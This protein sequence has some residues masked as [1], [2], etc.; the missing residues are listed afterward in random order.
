MLTLNFYPYRQFL[1]SLIL[2]EIHIYTVLFILFCF[3]VIII[4][5]KKKKKKRERMKRE[6]VGPEQPG[7]RPLAHGAPSLS[8]F[9]LWPIWC[10]LVSF[11]AHHPSISSPSSPPGPSSPS[12]PFSHLF[13]SARGRSPLKSRLHPRFLGE[14]RRLTHGRQR[15]EKLTYW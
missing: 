5:R 2:E 7:P 11:S 13:G 8:N 1:F 10:H 9:L 14:D 15:D 3:S 6:E 12:S 4:K